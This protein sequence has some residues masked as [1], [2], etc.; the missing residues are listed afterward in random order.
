MVAGSP[1]CD[2]CPS[3]ETQKNLTRRTGE[4]SASGASL[5]PSGGLP[6][7]W[8][9][10]SRGV[11]GGDLLEVFTGFNLPRTFL[12]LFLF[13]LYPVGIVCFFGW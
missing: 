13:R 9:S 5:R 11:G 8:F 10:S 4:V 2:F 3:V 1:L 6:P 12:Q 7:I